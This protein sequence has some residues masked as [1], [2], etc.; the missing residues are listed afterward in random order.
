VTLPAPPTMTLPE[1]SL[2]QQPGRPARLVDLTLR[3]VGGVV[4]FL[5]GALT[6]LVEL[7][8][9]TFRVAGHLVGVSV[10]I[11]IGANIVLSW[12]AHAA[13][14]RR[15]AVVLP[16]LP[17]F[18]AM[19][20]AAGRT[21]EGDLLLAGD[22]WVGLAMIVVGAMTFA[23]MGF[24]LIIAPPPHARRGPVPPV[25]PGPAPGGPTSPQGGPTPPQGTPDPPVRG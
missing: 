7:L 23:V 22:N 15:W 18:A 4:A 11:A 24:R 2:P 19:V 10:L 8:L 14:G 6:A 1:E 5:A 20:V 17:W 9:A 3:V 25:G 16:A 12:F 13:V 21:D